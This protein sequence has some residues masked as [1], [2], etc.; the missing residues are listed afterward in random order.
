MLKR[1]N[2]PFSVNW[3]TNTTIRGIDQTKY[4]FSSTSVDCVWIWVKSIK[5]SL[6]LIPIKHFYFI[7]K[8]SG[9]VILCDTHTYDV[10]YIRYCTV[11]F[12]NTIL[13]L[14]FFS[15]TLFPKVTSCYITNCVEYFY[16]DF[17][18]YK[19]GKH[20]YYVYRKSFRFRM[21]WQRSPSLKVYICIV[22]VQKVYL[23]FKD[24]F[25]IF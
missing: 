16:A 8:S 25:N 17:L 4:Y 6:T 24:A 7:W 23:Y 22:L 3:K 18:N 15:T 1:V 9:V 20:I 11:H 2:D 14:S 19:R 5:L 10:K 21:F 12:S 13:W